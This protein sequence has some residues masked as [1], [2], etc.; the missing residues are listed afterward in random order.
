LPSLFKREV[1]E[2][3]KES[4]SQKNALKKRER[5]SQTDALITI[6]KGCTGLS[7]FNIIQ[8]EI[9]K[10]VQALKGSCC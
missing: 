2:V 1:K 7:P 9:G 8:G 5:Q 10:S 4:Q 6:G 3:F